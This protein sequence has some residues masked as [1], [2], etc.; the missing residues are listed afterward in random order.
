MWRRQR[1]RRQRLRRQRLRLRRQRLRRLRLWL[2]RRLLFVVWR[3]LHLLV[4]TGLQNGRTARASAANCS[5]TMR[6]GGPRRTS[7]SCRRC[8]PSPV[9]RVLEEAAK[10]GQP[11]EWVSPRL[12]SISFALGYGATPANGASYEDTRVDRRTAFCGVACGSAN[13]TDT[14]ATRCRRAEKQFVTHQHWRYLPGGNRRDVLQ[15]GHQPEYR[16]L[17]DAWRCSDEH[18]LSGYPGLWRRCGSC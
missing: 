9:F 12:F 15:R 11:G 16:G 4:S 14:T 10:E 1:L 18:A 3:L 17:R 6:R 8:L 2:R 7:P 5:P 13:V